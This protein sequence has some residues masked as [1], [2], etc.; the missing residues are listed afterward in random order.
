MA[1]ASPKCPLPSATG[2]SFK[3]SLPSYGEESPSFRKSYFQTFPAF[4]QP[5]L[6][7][8]KRKKKA[9]KKAPNAHQCTYAEFPWIWWAEHE[10]HPPG[11]EAVGSSGK[12]WH[13][14]LSVHL[15]SNLLCHKTRSF[16]TRFGVNLRRQISACDAI[17]PNTLGVLE[18]ILGEWWTMI[19][20]EEWWI[21]VSFTPDAKFSPTGLVHNWILQNLHEKHYLQWNIH[22][23]WRCNCDCEAKAPTKQWP[24]QA[25]SRH[26][27]MASFT[28]QDHVF[29][30]TDYYELFRLV[31]LIYVYSY[32][33]S[34]SLWDGC[35]PQGSLGIHIVWG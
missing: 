30:V 2:E 10:S 11:M 15:E 29:Y 35:S 14:S 26:L 1:Q 3:P 8:R 21:S 28:C 17:E 27:S 9:V 33:I 13:L 6:L 5:F 12:L 31:I 34:T 25:T 32:V 7:E 16:S 18:G 19:H 24:S 23:A 22:I 4:F 20:Q